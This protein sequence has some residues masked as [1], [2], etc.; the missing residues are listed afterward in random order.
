M[1]CTLKASTYK[2]ILRFY[3]KL[4]P[5]FLQKAI[6]I[7]YDLINTY[8]WTE[9]QFE[10]EKKVILNQIYERETYVKI[11]PFVDKTVWGDDSL[12]LEIMGTPESVQKLKI[13]DLILHKKKCFS[14][15][16]VALVIVGAIEKNDIL[17][18][19]NLMSNCNINVQKKHCLSFEKKYN[20][21]FEHRKPSICFSDFNWNYLDV[22]IS[23]DVNSSKIAANTL[24]LLNAIIGGGEG[25][26]LQL[27]IREKAGLSSNIYSSVEQYN[28]ASVIHIFF[29]VEKRN[30]YN[31]IKL[32]FEQLKKIKIEISDACLKTNLPYFTH[33]LW[34]WQEDTEFLNFQLALE[35]FLR[36]K[37]EFSIEKTIDEYNCISKNDLITAAND[38]FKIENTTVTVLGSTNKLTKKEI[39]HSIEENL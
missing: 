16:N 7:F 29:S 21:I 19:N 10:S 9:E 20:K 36:K 22:N 37:S 6:E 34:F 25:S 27:T 39:K 3:M 18:I 24:L 14:K 33:N 31:S 4:R 23:F 2:D 26:L 28:D 11:N 38:I 8:D 30:F 15:E 13:E 1:G 35:I 12:G 32:I 17:L 5:Q